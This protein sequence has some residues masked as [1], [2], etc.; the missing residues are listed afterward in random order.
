[1]SFHQPGAQRNSRTRPWR[2]SESRFQIRSGAL[3]A[4]HPLRRFLFRNRRTIAALFFCAAAGVAV[5]ALLPAGQAL[6]TVV[7]ATSDLAAGTVLEPSHVS[8]AQLPA[9]AL[10]AEA[11]ENPGTLPGQQLATPLRSGDVVAGNFLVGPGLLTGAPAGTVAV[12]LRPADPSTVQLLAPGRRVDV[13][14]STGNGYET[15]AKSTV[16][17]RALP[18]LWTSSAEDSGTWPGSGSRQ[19]GLVVVAAA[20]DE[21]ASLAGASSTGKVHLVLTGTG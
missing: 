16:L 7:V 11:V 4:P 13:V 21:A 19:G 3:R 10:P 2:R 8:T 17:A 1:M 18:V 9:D 12:P 15:A 5:Q 20:P 6:R 14:L